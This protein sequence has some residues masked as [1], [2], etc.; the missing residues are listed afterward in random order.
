MQRRRQILYEPSEMGAFLH[1]HSFGARV[2]LDI[3]SKAR[4]LKKETP[5]AL[6]ICRLGGVVKPFM[7]V[8][9]EG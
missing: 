2:V 4:K 7:N 1:V 9:L 8:L 3:K 6:D 5:M